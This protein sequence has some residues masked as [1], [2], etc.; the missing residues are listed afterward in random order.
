MEGSSSLP[1]SGESF[2]LPAP[3]KPTNVLHE[4]SEEDED[5]DGEI[6]DEEI[7]PIYFY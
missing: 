4:S 5:Y 6:L 1:I 2:S 3:T 7:S